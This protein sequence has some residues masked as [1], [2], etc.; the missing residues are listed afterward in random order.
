MGE[1]ALTS[2][3]AKEIGFVF[4]SFNLIPTLTASENVQTALVPL[5]LSVAERHERAAAA[6]EEVGLAHRARHLPGEL[7][8]G[9]Q[10]RTAIARAIVKEPRVVL[11]DEPTGNL[12]QDTRDEIVSVL[13]SMWATHG[14]TLVVVTHDDQVAMRAPVLAR[15]EDGRISQL[16]PGYAT[17]ALGRREAGA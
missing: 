17:Q 15:L 14:V 3:R 10:Q 9:E 16:T 11:A 4:Q 1:G 5:G 6:L 13:E 7:S 12:D 8:G 2:M